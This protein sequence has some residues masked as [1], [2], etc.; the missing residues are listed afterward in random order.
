[1]SEPSAAQQDPTA[2]ML[3]KAYVRLLV[4]CAVIGLICSLAAWLFLSTVPWMQD[5]IYTRLPSALGFAAAPWWWPLPVLLIAGLITAFCIARLPGGGGGVPAEG[6]S[7]GLTQPIALPGILL[8]ALATLGFG[9]VLGPSTPVIATGS[10]VALLVFRFVKPDAP[11][12]T[13]KVVA[14]AGMFAAF[15]MIFTNPVIAAVILIEAIGLGGATLTLILIPGLL[16]AGIGALVYLGAQSITGLD[17][18]SFV[19]GPVAL[20][21]MGKLSLAA[22]GWTVLL[23]VLASAAGFVIIQI[24]RRLKGPV[25]RRPFVAVPIA[26][27]V[28]ASLVIIYAQVTG[29]TQYAVLFSGSRALDPLLS[30]AATLSLATLGLLFLLKGTAWGISMGSFRGGPVFP[31][32]FIG[33]VAGLL[34]QNLPGFS[35]G[36][37]VPALIAAMVATTLRLPFSAIVIAMFLCTS[38]GPSALP[39]IIIAAVIAHLVSHALFARRPEA[40]K[41]SAEEVP[42]S[43]E[44]APGPA[45]GRT[46]GG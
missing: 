17:T 41:T 24:G 37:A 23:A 1:V 40:A 27:L 15:A 44:A 46:G 10:G 19:I 21:S 30:H 9:L 6:L 20:P 45:A 32:I 4:L 13:K 3:S 36:A 35:E 7:S 22:I 26:G 16:A 11:D 2:V 34:A 39:L 38:A 42:T 5:T 43:A 29:Q 31:A 8:A 33:T 25:K 28:V 18:S 14:T 12:N